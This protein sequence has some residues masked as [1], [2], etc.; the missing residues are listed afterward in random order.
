MAT[1]HGG[2]LRLEVLGS[3]RVWRDGTELAV[4]PRQ[5]A[6]LLAVLLARS[7]Q[8]VSTAELIDLVWAGDAPAS[9]PTIVHK[10]VGALRRLFEP[11]LPARASGSYLQREGSGYRFTA[12]AGMLDT[13]LFR[14]HVDEAR[15]LVAG[16]RIPCALDAYVEALGLWRGPVGEGL[17][18]RSVF[19]ALE[20]ELLE[21]A[22]AA[23]GLAVSSGAPT[24]VLRP[25]RL[26]AALAPLHE[27]VQAALVSV[28]AACGLQAEALEVFHRVR[29][30]LA[31][32]FGI[33]PGPELQAALHRV[34]VPASP[35]PRP[36]TAVVPARGL[37]GRTAEVAALEVALASGGGLVLV[38]G[39]PGAGKTRLLEEAAVRA[40]QRG[41]LVVWGRCP[42]DGGAPPLWPWTQVVGP[43][44]DA[45]P[46]LA[47][48]RWLAGGL[49]RLLRPPEED[50]APPAAG[51][52]H[53]LFEHTVAALG[54]A[55]ARGPVVLLFD[56]LQWADATSLRL[57]A[58][59]APRLPSG[60]TVIGA[61]RAGP[62]P[63]ADELTAALAAISRTP[64]H[65]RL[66]LGP[67]D[68]AEVA[69]LVRAETGRT[70]D[71][72]TVLGI[73]TR[74]SGNPFFVR[75]LARLL[76]GAGAV[77]GPV[78]AT[79]R[80][81]VR[82]R[83]AGLPA[84][85]TGLLRLA[86]LIGREVELALLARAAGLD[87]SRCL[88]QV[89]P[90]LAL[91]LLVPVPENP[92]ALR[93]AHDLV[94][95]SVASTTSPTTA[96][97]WHLA[98]ADALAAAP[99]TG[100]ERLAHHLWSA[101]PLADP[102]RTAE[103]LLRAGRHAVARFA[104]DAADR[105]L[106]A[107]VTTARTAGLVELELAALTQLNLVLGMHLGYLD[108][109]LEPLERAE[110]LA[111]G[112]GR[113]LEATEILVWRW[114]VATALAQ[115]DL[116]GRLAH[117]LLVQGE[118]SPDPAIRAY[119]QHAWGVHQR[120]LGNIGQAFRHLGQCAW[121][122]AAEPGR[123][124]AQLRREH[125]L[126]SSFMFAEVTA[127]RGDLDTARRLLEQAR[128]AAVTPYATVMWATFTAAI[129]AMVGDPAWTLR[130]AARG[131]EAEPEPSFLLHRALLRLYQCWAEAMTGGDPVRAAAEAHRIITVD[132]DPPRPGVAT[133]YG[134]LGDIHLAAGQLPEAA[135]ALDR[136]DHFLDL[137]GQRYPEWLLL[138]LRAKLLHA[139]AEPAPTVLAAAER[140]R[141]LAAE[142]GVL[143]YAH[144]AD[145]LVTAL[146]S[147]G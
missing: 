76:T 23:A 16:Q 31:E 126:F 50:A 2:G 40:G 10:Y 25:L 5:Q 113:D 68:P 94:R 118:S 144:R 13:D 132:L 123:E 67:L 6:C 38:E 15:E 130:A 46:D 63:L 109:V 110:D 141:A 27:P 55:A 143:L 122:T 81:V 117:R 98:L 112:L 29:G 86:A 41:A 34:L 111:R 97:R 106:R 39:E 20:Q 116:S 89:D 65:R 19:R 147:G 82:H 26:A 62:A 77:A 72:D 87:L 133:W 103:A 59:L 124:P 8:A 79:V 64:E 83:L 75:E 121:P 71:L 49:G 44:L 48:D 102:E 52:Q 139:R 37:V 14:R 73:H 57:L 42:E 36:G 84:E 3:L 129:A 28:L 33:D 22:T 51:S 11:D 32:E 61:F 35:A 47:R 21:A 93:F 100:A 56:D 17:A 140:A 99:H 60:C 114:N 12:G 80:D 45:L 138:L 119:A 85:C 146:T 30:Q 88:D 24:R 7:G 54:E 70:P 107:A 125:Q 136:A 53:R 95:E 4:G 131:L 43:V 90:L 96:L 74:T 145:Q 18:A 134:L 104:F 120:D 9:A 142:R 58:H 127:L 78:P 69:E 92:S 1:S 128:A 105:L 91:G 115:V 135:A 108:S 137:Y 101:G 66:E